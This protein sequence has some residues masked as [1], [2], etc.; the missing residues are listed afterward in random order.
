MIAKIQIQKE[1]AGP[2]KRLSM[3]SLYLRNAMTIL[4]SDVWV[5]HFI[6]TNIMADKLVKHP[7]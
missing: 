4:L 5:H 1:E 3:F 7:Q 6:L 2:E